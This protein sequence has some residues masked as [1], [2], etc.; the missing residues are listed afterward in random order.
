M[1][2]L[3]D[4][5]AEVGQAHDGSLGMAH[6]YIDALHNIGIKTIKFQMHIAD[7]ESSKGE[8]FRVNFSYQD[9]SRYDYWKRNEFTYEQWFELKKHC[10]KIGIEFI[11]TPFSVTAIDFLNKLNVKRIKIGSGEIENDLM[12]NIAAKT[13]KRLMLSSGM[14]KIKKMRE[15]YDNIKNFNGKIDTI[16]HCTSSYP[17][18][19][20][21][22]NLNTLLDFKNLFNCKIGLSDHSSNL[23]TL[24]SAVLLGAQALEFHVVFSKDSF[25]PDSKS[26]LTINETANLLK[27]IRD[28]NILN[29]YNK[30]KKLIDNNMKNLFSR[31]L[32]AKFDLK[33]NQILSIKHFECGKGNKNG[34]D[35]NQYKS[36]LGKRLKNDI[37]KYQFICKSDIEYL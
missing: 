12:L 7:A 26:S 33:K 35:V 37:S 14:T 25:G 6:A 32:R 29:R 9:N 19:L 23:N 36:I 18:R 16:F 13:K 21:N 15:I 5:V 3:S 17:T 10:D 22:V 2:K 20:E 1:I 31:S 8:K 11:C 28:I 24:R 4:I 34:I 27:D 30:K